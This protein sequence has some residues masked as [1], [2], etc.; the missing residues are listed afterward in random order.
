MPSYI[1]INGYPGVGKLTIANELLKLIPGSKVLH[2]HLFIDPVAAMVER[3]SPE[4]DDIRSHL[5][6]EI[7]GLLRRPATR[8]T[9]WIFTDSRCTS[10]TGSAAAEDYREA[11]AV[12][13]VP[14]VSV[15]VDCGLEENQRR[16]VREGR[17][18]GKNT[19]LTDVGILEAVRR[20][21]IM[22][23]F[24]GEAELELDVSELTPVEAARMILSH[25]IAVEEK[26]QN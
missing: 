16:L 11:A 15:V 14:F 25:V 10:A 3:S 21:E 12:R 23:R 13:G 9:T 5:R 20:E 4:Y 24:G 8:D 22:F 26:F 2:N 1:Y 6:R 7:L 19:K 18:E 17:G